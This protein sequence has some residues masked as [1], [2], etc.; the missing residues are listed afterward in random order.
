[1][2][3]KFFQYREDFAG[4]AVEIIVHDH[5]GR[6]IMAFRE[7]VRGAGEAFGNVIVTVSTGSQALF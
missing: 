1:V 3:T 5:V 2:L 7:L 4:R 6:Q